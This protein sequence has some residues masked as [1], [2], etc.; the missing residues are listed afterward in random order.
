[1]PLQRRLPKVG[2]TSRKSR[3]TDEVRLHELDGWK[4]GVIDLDALQAGQCRVAQHHA[5]E[6]DRLGR[7]STRP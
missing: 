3:T 1:M 6:G 4:R 5:G 7:P 2:F